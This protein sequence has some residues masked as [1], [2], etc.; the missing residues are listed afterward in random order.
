VKGGAVAPL[1]A[2]VAV[3]AVGSLVVA[4][5]VVVVSAGI[6]R[7][8]REWSLCR[9]R[10]PSLTAWIARRVGGLYVK[11][12]EHEEPEEGDPDHSLHRCERCV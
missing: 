4:G 2:L 3:V 1:Y 8:E 10:A 5:L 6:R 12:T 11:K 7:E 9:K